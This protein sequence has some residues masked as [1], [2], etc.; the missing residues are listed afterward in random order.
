MLFPLGPLHTHL[1]HR[2][3]QDKEHSTKGRGFPPSCS[4]LPASSTAKPNTEVTG[5]GEISQAGQQKVNLELKG[6]KVDNWHIPNFKYC[7]HQTINSL[8]FSFWR[9]DYSVIVNWSRSWLILM[10][11]TKWTI[12]NNLFL[13]QDQFLVN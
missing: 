6:K 11:V 3:Q 8:V 4:I 10:F 9:T 5:K 13:F 1:Y 12:S 7:S 2:S